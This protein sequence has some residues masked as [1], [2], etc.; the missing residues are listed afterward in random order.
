[1]AVKNKLKRFAPKFKIRKGDTVQVIAG[2]EK[3]KTGIVLEVQPAKS[4]AI[5]EGLNIVYKHQKATQNEEGGIQE[6]EAPIHISNLML[7]DPT[8]NEPVRV[9]YKIN[10]NGEKVRFSKKTGNIIA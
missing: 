5:V 9:G 3:G 4:R 6:M 7:V 2:D 8:T 10:E 1:M